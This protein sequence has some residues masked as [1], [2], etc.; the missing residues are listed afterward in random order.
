MLALLALAPALDFLPR[1]KVPS[2]YRDAVDALRAIEVCKGRAPRPSASAKHVFHIEG[3]DK[4]VKPVHLRRVKVAA[5]Y[6][7]HF[8]AAKK[9]SFPFAD[10]VVRYMAPHEYYMLHIV[11]VRGGSE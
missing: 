11:P 8:D 2:E 1:S 4:L 9:L 6:G 10:C 3:G 5:G 7:L